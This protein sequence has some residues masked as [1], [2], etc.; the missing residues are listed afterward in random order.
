MNKKHEVLFFAGV[1]GAEFPPIAGRGVQFADGLFLSQDF[2]Q[3]EKRVPRELPVRLGSIEYDFLRDASAFVYSARKI[4]LNSF[5]W[6][7][8]LATELGAVNLLFNTIWLF[9]D[10]AINIELGYLSY[11]CNLGRNF[12]SNSIATVYRKAGGTR[13]I[14]RLDSKELNEAVKLHRKHFLADEYDDERLTHLITSNSRLNRA[15]Y[16]IQAGRSAPDIGERIAASCT[17]L[18]TLFTT[19]PSELTHQLAERVAYFLRAVPSERQLIYRSLK[20]AYGYRSKVVHGSV[21]KQSQLDSAITSAKDLDRILREIMN[22]IIK[23][24][25]INQ[26]FHMDNNEFEERMIGLIFGEWSAIE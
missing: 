21:F 24:D 20:K 2:S 10:N 5:D 13:D 22:V 12:H 6:Q 26:I 23:S 7:V 9:E 19:S 3:L 15:F 4:D 16:W 8:Y 1:L 17:A 11:P 14:V 25:V 18:E